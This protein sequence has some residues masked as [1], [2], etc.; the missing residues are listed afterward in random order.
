MCW[1]P[2]LIAA[3]DLGEGVRWGGKGRVCA[4]P[5]AWQEKLPSLNLDLTTAQNDNLVPFLHPG[6]ESVFSI[7]RLYA[8]AS[9]RD[10]VTHTEMPGCW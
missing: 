4:L 5:S 10:E 6:R 3:V 8:A 9:N 2:E 1:L 7:P